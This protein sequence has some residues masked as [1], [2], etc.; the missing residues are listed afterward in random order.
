MTIPNSAPLADYFEPDLCF[1]LRR[2]SIAIEIVRGHAI[3]PD[4]AK[5]FKVGFVGDTLVGKTTLVR[6]FADRQWAP[7]SV[8]TVGAEWKVVHFSAKQTMLEMR[9]WDVAGDLR[10]RS[11]VPIYILSAHA[12]VIM[13]DL[14]NRATFDSLRGWFADVQDRAPNAVKVLVGGKSD[15]VDERQVE[16]AEAEE[17]AHELRIAYVETSAKADENVTELFT[18]LARPKL[19]SLLRPASEPRAEGR[20]GGCVLI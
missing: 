13:F 4:D 7:Q 6:R 15:L 11:L 16:K 8:R 10:F 18:E 20:D 14:T 5:Q 3:S 12:V 1:I 17:L 9:V 19:E 2:T